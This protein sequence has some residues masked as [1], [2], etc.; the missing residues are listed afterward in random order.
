VRREERRASLGASLQQALDACGMSQAEAAALIGVDASTLGRWAD[1]HD[2]LSISVAD[3][4]ALPVSVRVA[5]VLS[6]LL[7]GHVVVREPEGVDAG[8]DLRQSAAA[9]RA[10]SEAS[11]CALDAWA[12]GRMTRGEAAPVV[13]ACDRAIALLVAVRQRA[14]LASREGV[15]AMRTQLRAV[16][17]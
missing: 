9:L 17:R 10:S 3:L 13:D 8:C 16:A 12:D 4:A 14:E 1:R 11:A 6:E 2:S 15:I 7:P 5:L